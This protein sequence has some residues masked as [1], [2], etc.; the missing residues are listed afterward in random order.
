M[1]SKEK[2][3]AG[4]WVQVRGRGE[5]LRTLDSRG[6]LDEMPFMPEMFAFCGKKFRV[7][8]RAHKTC[9]TVFPIR[10]RRVP[11]TVHLETRCNG[12][13][14]GGCQAGCLL[15][16]KTAWLIP[17]NDDGSPKDPEARNDNVASASKRSS[18]CTE[19]DVWNNAR[20]HNGTSG[21]KYMCQ[22]TQLP[23]YTSDLKWWELWQYL[24][25]YTSGNIGLWRIVC[26]L[27]YSAYY[28]LIQAGIGLGAPLRELYDLFHPF[29]GGKKFPRRTGSIPKGQATPAAV[30]DL[31]PG[32]LVRVKSHDEIL[33]TLNTDCSNRGM[34]WDAEMVPYC[35]KTFRVLDRVTKIVNEQTGFMQEMKTPC[36]ILDNVICQSR[37]SQCRMFCPRSIY[38]Y[39]RE[40]WLERVEQKKPR[41]EPQEAAPELCSSQRDASQLV[42]IGPAQ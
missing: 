37:Y 25:D 16:W 23:Y 21:P 33:R 41:R 7:Y 15:F 35:G 27:A 32:E 26:G 2:L 3:S 28:N 34:R 24:E 38:S 4:D 39:W 17:L 10:G 13:A 20:P 31:Q 12:A 29:R 30:L 36:I 8:K 11:D 18:G 40:I 19:S 5:I 42:E 14:H 9:D 22:A 1:K 6:C